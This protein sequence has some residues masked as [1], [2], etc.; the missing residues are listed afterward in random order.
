MT[1]ALT[2]IPI[3]GRMHTDVTAFAHILQQRLQGTYR[4]SGTM[5]KLKQ[6]AELTD[7]SVS[8]VSRVLTKKGKISEETR[9]KVLA[10]VEELAIEPGIIASN[11]PGLAQTFA[12]YIP[13]SGEFY[14]DD[15]TSSQDLRSLLNA[16]EKFGVKP[17]LMYQNRQ[18]DHLEL[19]QRFEQHQFDGLIICDPLLDNPAIEALIASHIPYLITNGSFRDRTYNGIDFNNYAGACQM[20]QYLLDM[21]HLRLGVIAGPDNHLVTQNR[22]DGVRDTLAKAERTLLPEAICY[23]DFSLD[24]GYDGMQ[25]L[26]AQAPQATAIFAFSDFIAMGAMKAIKEHGLRIPEDLSIVGFDNLKIADFCDPGLTTV[27]RFSKEISYLLVRTLQDL[28]RFGDKIETVTM[29]LKTELVLRQS[30]RKL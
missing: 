22:L 26:F 2:A 11:L 30:V 24:G 16:C 17:E 9:Q 4:R 29:Q 12:I 10:A 6:I 7:V 19:F 20:T 15:P 23:T 18:D 21:G 5:L 1:K 25:R 3:Y 14:Q 28:I 27:N 13:P 8:T